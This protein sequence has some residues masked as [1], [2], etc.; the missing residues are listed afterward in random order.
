MKTVVIDANIGISYIIPLPYSDL[1]LQRMFAWQDEQA[2]IV[3]PALWQYE[4]LSGLRKAIS[5]GLLTFAQ[6]VSAL[7]EI[8]DLGF[9]VL[10]SDLETDQRTLIWAERIGQMV[11]YDATYLA[12]A[13]QIDAE[14]WT[15]DRRLA[16]SAIMAGASWVHLLGD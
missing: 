16:N 9:E 12:L 14:F 13:E 3:V 7:H 15:A 6:A 1:T 4:V 5:S 8:E 2:N 10:A 11:I